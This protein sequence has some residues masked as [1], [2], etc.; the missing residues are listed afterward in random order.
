[1]KLH[2]WSQPLI[3]LDFDGTLHPKCC[4]WDATGPYLDAPAGHK[5][6]E[7]ARLL[8]RILG[9]F[10]TVGVVLHSLWTERLGL[11]GALA[12]LPPG[13]RGRVVGNTLD[14]ATTPHPLIRLS[15][16]E[17]VLLDVERRKPSGWIALDAARQGWPEWAMA[18]VLQTHPEEG[19]SPV[20]VQG[21]LHSRLLRIAGAS[22]C[23]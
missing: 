12:H 10:P 11:N 20:V 2:G 7:H 14:G 3:Y 4:L 8:D 21:A 22:G 19:I 13:L 6:F 17:R 1:M 23:A 16:A 9:E 5:L 15:P 18:H